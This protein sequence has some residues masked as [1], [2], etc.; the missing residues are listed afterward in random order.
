MHLTRIAAAIATVTA[1]ASSSAQSKPDISAWRKDL[2]MIATTLPSTHPN[3]FYRMKRESWDS[4]VA[5][6]D[7]R[8]PSMTR[9]QAMVAFGQL[10]AMV[11]DGHTSI[12]P[13]FDRAM[14]IHYYPVRF[15]LFDDGLFIR[16]A[17]PQF[18]S[19]V[20]A[21][22]IRIGKMSS[23]EALAAL[24]TTI[25]H[26][27]E[28]F[29]RAYAPVRL[30]LS[31]ILDG[32][33]IVS[34]PSRLPVVIEKNGK[35]ETVT[36]EPTGHITPSGHNPLGG[37]DMSGWVEMHDPAKVALWQ[38][39]SDRPY[40]SEFIASDS[41]LFVSYRAVMSLDDMPNT[42]FWRNVFATADS[43]PVKRLVLDIRENGGGNSFFNRQVIRGIVA[44][45]RL[46]RR[47]A[48]FV[49]T[50]GRTFSAAMN[51][52]QDL[53]Q[54]TNATFVG[55][56]TG[57]ATVFFG[58]HT[59]IVLPVSGI[60][61]NVSTL[62]WYPADPKDSRS[63]IAPRL[64]APLT[65]TA[66][67][68]SVDPAMQAILKYSSG[69]STS[70]SLEAAIVRGDTTTAFQIVTDAARDPVNRFRSP[71]ADINTLGYRLL[72]SNRPAALAAF[73]INV[74]AFPNSANAWDSYGE[75]LLT[76]GQ[77]DAAIA[78]YRKAVEL[79]PGFPSST[80]A[81]QRLGIR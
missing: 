49:I 44:R 10:V 17:A 13:L 52:A 22:V 59:Q 9:N 35:R 25:G 18:A 48:L 73:R 64:Y 77:R 28:W 31:E 51:L 68:A 40:W 39:H 1:F 74:R 29:V 36:L 20:G 7:A 61:V 27:N 11:S 54:W 50:S 32:L 6:I 41:T 26:E 43:L 15:E 71:E 42:T 12:N 65:S 46:D 55:E 37:Y 78:A 45:P 2:Q 5:S 69:V 57:N 56:P 47:D 66:Y 21:K 60:T 58:D 72:P 33:G 16:S 62:P 23:D 70:A 79:R 8:L 67:K 19:M 81:L 80:E 63:F 14:D 3:A 4:A 38:Q 24:T 34:D 76:D 53:E 75:A 30:N